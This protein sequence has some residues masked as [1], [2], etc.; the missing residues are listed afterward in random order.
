MGSVSRPERY[1]SHSLRASILD[2]LGIAET[3]NNKERYSRTKTSFEIAQYDELVTGCTTSPSL[4]WCCKGDMR[5]AH[6]VLI[7]LLHTW[8]GICVPMFSRSVPDNGISHVVASPSWVVLLGKRCLMLVEL[9]QEMSMSKELRKVHY[10]RSGRNW[11]A[12][13]PTVGR[14]SVGLG[15]PP[16]P[17]R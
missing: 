14:G 8:K 12:V 6:C 2:D 13:G 3:K 17:W 15:V 7:Q 1:G 4:S 5:E 9:L 10:D 11:C 16:G